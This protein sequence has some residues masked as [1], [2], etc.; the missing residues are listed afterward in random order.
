MTVVL[1]AGIVI[2]VEVEFGFAT[3]APVHL[4][5][6][7]PCGGELA[8]IETTFPGAY[9]PPPVPL[10]TVSVN[11]LIGTETAFETAL[12][13]FATVKLALSAVS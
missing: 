1:A 11:F 12:P 9:D 7:W 4:L 13:T 8:E 2:V 3:V 5:K 10:F 6:T